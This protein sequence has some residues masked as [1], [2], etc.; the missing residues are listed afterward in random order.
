MRPSWWHTH[1]WGAGVRHAGRGAGR[2]LASRAWWSWVVLAHPGRA[3]VH[4]HGRH[5]CG[6]KGVHS[7]GRISLLQHQVPTAARGA[8]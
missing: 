2:G 5:S 6:T 8:V 3:V 1:G 4:L 7:E